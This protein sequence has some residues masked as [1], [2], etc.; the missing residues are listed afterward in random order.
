MRFIHNNIAVIS[1][2]ILTGGLG[3]LYGGTVS[4]VLRPVVPW[5]VVFMLDMALCFPQRRDDESTSFARERVWEAMRND[6]LVWVVVAFLLLMCIPFFNVGLI[7]PMQYLPYCIEPIWHYNV[8]QWFL[9][10]LAAAVVAK[11]SLNRMGKRTLVEMLVWNGVALAVLGFVQQV[12]GASGPLWIDMGKDS[13]HFFSTFGYPN[14]A[15]DYF[16]VLFC[17]S[18]AQWRE[19][20]NEVRHTIEATHVKH[21][22]SS[23]RLFWIKNYMLIPAL[24]NF[25]AALN[26]LS[27]AA[28]IMVSVSA[29]I[30][31]AHTF[32]MALSRM[33]KADR[34]RAGAFC[35]LALLLIAV[36]AT[37]FMPDGVQREMKTV[38]SR[39]ALDRVTGRGER[40]SA[41]ATQIWRENLLFGCGGWGYARICDERLP[42]RYNKGS[43][44]ANVHN[45]H[46]QFLTEHGLV[47]YGL[48]VACVV[49]LLIPTGRAWIK[50]SKG[51]RFLPVKRQP[52]P[53]QSFFA[54]PG[55]A[56]AMLVAAAVPVVH[57]FGD[58]PLRSP[59]V[60]TLFFVTLA[61]VGGY[62]PRETR[63]NR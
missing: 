22:I 29:V 6:P 17:L 21:L 7:P 14:M 24:V 39:E 23:H 51:T 50:I 35:A 11:H 9:C 25:F 10:A 19:R 62:L 46:L 5:L 1:I 42:I 43:G 38:D 2:F 58:C 13:G 49:L 59:A 41:M 33:H 48:L 15:G 12:A 27:R 26:T 53:P 3:W 28:I 37:T 44:A 54:L 55:S 60:L 30:L 45:D 61:C 34:V 56:F 63:G 8:L 36:V 32:V 16:T 52:P 18:M 20:V 31:F 47:G 4:A 57:A 40:H